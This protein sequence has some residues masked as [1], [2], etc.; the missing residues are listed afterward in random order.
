MENVMNLTLKIYKHIDSNLELKIEKF[1]IENSTLNN[2]NPLFSSPLW[3]LRLKKM[4]SF[5]FEYLLVSQ[6][7][8]MVGLS[9]IFQGYRGYSRITKLP[10]FLKT[11]ISK[12]LMVCFPYIS[13]GNPIIVKNDVDSNI[14][15][16]CK[17]MIYDYI[18]KKQKTVS[19]SPIL[20]TEIEYF[21][22]YPMG[23]WGT[24]IIDFKHRTYEELYR[25][26][27]RQGRKSIE[28]AL[29]KG[30]VVKTLNIEDEEEL[31][32]YIRFLKD[33]QRVTGKK[34]IIKKENILEE[35][36]R[37]KK[38][39]Y[40]YEI[41]LAY[42]NNSIHGSL[43]IWGF[44][45]FITEHGVNYTQ[46]SK[47]N[48]LYVQDAIKNSIIKYCIDNGIHYYDLAGFNPSSEA[49]QKEKNIKRFKEKFGGEKFLYYIVNG[50]RS[51]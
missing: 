45:N 10:N 40:I 32:K 6:D 50:K 31:N 11:S 8:E 43:G 17:K 3:A 5:K 41:F 42:Y 2:L 29:E 36:K 1:L 18:T 20:E 35:Y 21:D 51:K 26:I 22:G 37:F 4:L 24:Y 44:N 49:T 34:Y 48:K 16:E 28:K 12:T 30:V 23:K 33:N 39:S 15:R 25:K 47:E 7:K 14:A 27:R 38:N 46:F 9:L 13:W 19:F